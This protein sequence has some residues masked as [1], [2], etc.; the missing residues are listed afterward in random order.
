MT[1][2]QAK[3]L[4]FPVVFLPAMEDETIPHY[5]ALQEGTDAIEEER[6][7]LYVAITRWEG[8]YHGMAGGRGGP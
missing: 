8:C 5:H 1:I 2:H 7:L 4:E 3:G 6:R